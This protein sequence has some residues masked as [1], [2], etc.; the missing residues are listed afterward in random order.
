MG[1]K[2][3]FDNRASAWCIVIEDEN[4]MVEHNGWVNTIQPRER[5]SVIADVMA[6]IVRKTI[7]AMPKNG[8][9]EVQLNCSWE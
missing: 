5:L 8:A 2:Q 6:D 3:K 7:I 9:K 1:D 4:V